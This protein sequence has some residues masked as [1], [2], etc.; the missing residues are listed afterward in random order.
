MVHKKS[1]RHTRTE[2]ALRVIKALES[3]APS[4]GITM[5]AEIAKEYNRDPFTILI[6][7]LLSLQTRDAI[8]LPVSRNLFSRA[9]T[10][11]E[12]VKIPISELE[13]IIYSTG[14][15][16]RKAHV[17]HAVSKDLITRFHGKVPHTEEELLSLPGV[18]LKTA[19]L[20]LA[21]AFGIP[22]IA[23]DTHVHRLSNQ[24]G[25]VDTK[26]PEQT[27][28]ELKKIIPEKDWI[29]VN[30]LLVLW[31]Q[32]VPRKKQVSLIQELIEKKK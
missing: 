2:Y 25:L 1:I 4:L 19:N 7:C 21:E 23:V 8:S 12:L 14:Y 30:K 3:A 10:P 28:A 9:K 17:L 5:S 32:N 18:G 16:H 15:Y 29:K 11:Q 20:V 13:K 24:L 22:A 6:S 27:E 26:T 31:G